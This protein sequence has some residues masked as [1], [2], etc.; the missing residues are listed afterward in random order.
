MSGREVLDE[1]V[2]R[3]CLAA[4]GDIYHG[5]GCG[6]DERHA[7]VA[8]QIAAKVHGHEPTDEEIGWFIEDAEHI[9][10]VVT[11]EHPVLT[12]WDSRTMRLVVNG[13]RFRVADEGGGLLYVGP[14]VQRPVR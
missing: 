5:H 1:P 11:D 14:P 8:R 6:H 4:W 9:C 13:H 12:R 3:Y 10:A 7:E 2:C